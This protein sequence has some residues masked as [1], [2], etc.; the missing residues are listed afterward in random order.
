M[1]TLLLTLA[2]LAAFT[3]VTF[4]TN[5]HCQKCV[6]KLEENLA[7][8]KGVKDLKVNL[9]DKTVYVRYDSTKTNVEKLRKVINKL[10]YSAEIKK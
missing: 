2:L 3:D 9:K 10:G 7:F 8:E 4:L 6:E 5:V 1:K